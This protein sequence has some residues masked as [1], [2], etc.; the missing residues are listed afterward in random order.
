MCF[1]E[2]WRFPGRDSVAGK[3]WAVKSLRERRN[4]FESRSESAR[5]NHQVPKDASAQGCFKT[6]HALP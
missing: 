4:C 1:S 6:P 2:G 3:S 5:Q